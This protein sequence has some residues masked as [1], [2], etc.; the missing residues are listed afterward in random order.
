MNTV[1][2]AHKKFV[3]IGRCLKSLKWT[4][5][6]AHTHTQPGGLTRLLSV[7]EERRLKFVKQVRTFHCFLDKMLKI[8]ISLLSSLRR[9]YAARKQWEGDT[10]EKLSC[11][12]LP[13]SYT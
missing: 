13:N 5:T 11:M 6:H 2:V 8:T 9:M 12:K 7:V 4:H 10:G 1:F 3:K